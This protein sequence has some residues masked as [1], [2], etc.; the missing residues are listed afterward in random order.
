MASAGKFVWAGPTDVAVGGLLEDAAREFGLSVRYCSHARLLD[1]VREEGCDVLGIEFG[2]RHGDALA[3]L[4]EVHARAPRLTIFAAAH[5]S[6]FQVL[7]EALEAGAADFFSLPLNVAELHK[8]LIRLSRTAAPAASSGEIVTVAGARGGVGVTTVAVNLAARLSSLTGAGVA[9]ADFDLQ[10]GD[11]SAFLNLNPLN[12]LATVATATGPVDDIFLAGTLT[13]HGS[14]FVL[15]A[16]PQIDDADGIGH[17]DAELALRLLRSQFRYTV[18]DKPRTITAPTVAAFEQADRILLVVDLSVPGVRAARRFM[19]LWNRMKVPF[20]RIGLLFSDIV[21]G[22]VSRDDAIRA[23]GKP[24]IVIIPADANA[25][26]AMNAG[27]PLNGKQSP[28]GVAIGELA[29]KIANLEVEPKARRGHLL[30]RIF[31][32]EARK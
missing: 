19:E 27:V 7:R 16:P 21:P 29:A 13:R 15:P 18:V 9:L 32:K 20:E 5:D 14:I 4:R 8:A 10:R 23:L 3:L 25:G 22:P 1:V 30:Q 31:T 12:S 2:P 6:G 26:K 28:L 11:V 24:P 17:G